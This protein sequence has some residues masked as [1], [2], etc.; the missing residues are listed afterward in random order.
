ML[1]S[2]NVTVLNAVEKSPNDERDYRLLTLA[3]ELDVLLIHDPTTD[4]SAAALDCNVG[5]LSDPE[6]AP[7]LAHFCEHMLFLG[8]EKY[9]VENEYSKFLSAHGGHSNAFTGTDNTNYYFEVD[10]GSLEGALDRFAQFFIAPL[11]APS[12]TDREMNAVDSEN[13]KNLQQDS[14]RLYQLEKN[15]SSPT[16]P[17]CKFG[18]GNLETLRDWPLQK[19]LDIR[20]ILLDFHAKYYSANVMKLVVVGKG[21]E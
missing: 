20:Q 2:S 17:F 7:G 12:C 9:P 5:H 18:T 14:W 3:N 21:E 16:H 6:V 19:E 1:E 4:K 15:L 10:A 11:F 8:T 13:K